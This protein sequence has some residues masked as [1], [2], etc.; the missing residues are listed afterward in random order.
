[1]SVSLHEST[2]FPR[3]RRGITFLTVSVCV[4]NL[5]DRDFL[6]ND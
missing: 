4:V 6:A 1:M 3:A 2:N 5:L